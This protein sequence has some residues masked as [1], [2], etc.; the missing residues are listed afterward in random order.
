MIPRAGTG[1]VRALY[2]LGEDPALTDPDTNHARACLERLRVHR[3]A[4]NLSRRRRSAYADVLLP[5][6]SFA[7]KSGT[8]TNTERRIQLV[9]QAIAPL[10]EARPD[11]QVTAELA[12]RLLALDGRGTDWA[13]RPA[14]ITDSPAQMMDEIAAL[15]PS[16]AGVS[17]APPGAGA[18][19]H[20][21]VARGRARR[22]RPSCM[23]ASSREARAVS[24]RLTTCRRGSCPTPNTPCC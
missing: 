8:F 7:E 9:R 20:W 14:G 12:R 13:A 16:Y 4:G 2:I 23:W 19:L 6:A 22:A 10:G 5:G 18:A 1:E 15:T 3:A 17:H 24:M 21:P 11:W